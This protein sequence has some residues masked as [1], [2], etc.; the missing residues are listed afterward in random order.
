MPYIHVLVS[1]Y[2]LLRIFRLVDIQERVASYSYKRPFQIFSFS[3]LILLVLSYFFRFTSNIIL[4]AEYLPLFSESYS[5]HHYDEISLPIFPLLRL[6]CE[7]HQKPVDAYFV[8]VI[9]K[10]QFKRGFFKSSSI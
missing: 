7:K 4:D 1:L 6:S 9:S 2:V 8:R 5:L 10:S 3:I